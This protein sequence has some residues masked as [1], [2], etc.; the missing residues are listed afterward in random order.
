LS[1]NNVHLQ[2]EWIWRERQD[3]LLYL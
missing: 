2:V 1:K 3:S